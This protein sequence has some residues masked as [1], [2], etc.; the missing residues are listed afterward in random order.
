MLLSVWPTAQTLLAENALTARRK[1]KLVPGLGVCTTFQAV[2]FQ[3]SA[4][5]SNGPP[6]TAR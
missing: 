6:E 4:R 1:L 3:C 2:P 5:L